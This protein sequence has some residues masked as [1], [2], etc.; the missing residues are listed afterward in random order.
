MTLLRYHFPP[1]VD[2]VPERVETDLCIYGASPAGITAAIQARQLGHRVE[3]CLPSAW[4][5]GLTT[6]GLSNTDIG[7]KGSIGGLAR[8]FY[9]RVGAVYGVTEEWRFEPKVAEQV[10][11]AWLAEHGILPRFRLHLSGAICR[12]GQ[13]LSVHFENGLVVAAGCFIDASYEGDLLAAAGATFTVGREPNATYG[14]VLN[15]C[16]VRET[17]QFDSPIDPWVVP[18]QPASGLLPG[19]STEPLAAPGTGDRVVQAYNFRVTGT[20][21]ADRRPWPQPAGYDPLDY[22]LL[23]RYLATGW[24]QVFRKFDPIRGHKVDINNHGPVSTDFIGGNHAFPTATP[25][26]REAIFQQHVRWQQGLFWFLAHDPRVPAAIRTEMNRWGLP[27]DEFIETGGWARQLYIR[28]ARRLVGDYVI[29]EHDCRGRRQA[30]DPI[31]LGAYGMDSHN[32][33]RLLVN[34]QVLNEGDVQTHGGRPYPISYRAIIPRRGEVTNL[35]VP[36]CVSASHIAYGSIR[37]EPVFMLLGQAAGLAAH[38]ALSANVPVQDVDY[39]ELRKRLEQAGQVMV[40]NPDQ[41]VHYEPEAPLPP[42]GPSPA[43]TPGTGERMLAQP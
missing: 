8:E 37:M 16:Q 27:A 14:E 36:V 39:T 3:L 43:S 20:T 6:G 19:V 9:R 28:E 29:T 18:G 21:A 26:A 17:H 12:D 13:I 41:A 30:E 40:W 11:G 31:G 33:R 1:P 22:E 2:T 25:A 5:G 15:G 23:A 7:N 42:A 32:G 4:L 10:L 24:N 35:L 38:L 34:G